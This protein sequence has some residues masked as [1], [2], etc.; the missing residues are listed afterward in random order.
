[1][2]SIFKKAL[3]VFVEFDQDQ[4]IQTTSDVQNTPLATKN[5]GISTPAPLLNQQEIDKFEKHFDSLFEK[6]NLPGPDYYEFFKMM[7][8]LEAH[9]PDEKTRISAVYASLSIQGLTKQKL[10]DTARTYKEV[11]N[12]DKTQFEQAID[13]KAEAELE[14]R[15]QN[16][17][18]LE[19]R[20][21][22]HAEL[23][24]NLTKE[25]TE[26]QSKISLLKEEI[27]QEET[28]LTNNKGGYKIACEAILNKIDADMLKILN[29]LQ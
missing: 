2:A 22:D 1:M 8:T 14:K 5:V 28:K 3:G 16:L 4:P 12:S 21:V 17:I 29:S 27:N 13:K 24:K 25:I 18:S 11:V 6:S 19:K 23:I 26:A 9:I 7:E 15:K 10:L 20:I